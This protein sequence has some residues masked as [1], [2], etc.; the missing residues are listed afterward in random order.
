M[1]ARTRV[2][3]HSLLGMTKGAQMATHRMATVVLR[4]DSGFGGGI[5]AATAAAAATTTAQMDGLFSIATQG[6]AR[7][8][9]RVDKWPPC[10]PSEPRE[11]VADPPRPASLGAHAF[12]YTGEVKRLL[13]PPAPFPA[14]PPAGGG[15]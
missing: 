15:A 12:T 5:A 3:I 10:L 8:W 7:D 6:R 14:P 9:G 13:K 4:H 11:F 2:L 1:G